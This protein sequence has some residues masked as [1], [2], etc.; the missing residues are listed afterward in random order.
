M[1]NR[2]I[3]PM[4]A[5]QGVRAESKYHSDCESDQPSGK[6]GADNFHV[7]IAAAADEKKHRKRHRDEEAKRGSYGRTPGVVVPFKMAPVA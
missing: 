2:V 3:H 1:T 5:E 6:V 4:S 7:G